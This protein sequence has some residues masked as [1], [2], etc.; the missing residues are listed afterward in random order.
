M[1]KAVA[2]VAFVGLAVGAWFLVRGTREEPAP[3][4]SSSKRT[5]A[6]KPVQ[7]ALPGKPEARTGPRYA[8]FDCARPLG[9]VARVDGVSL[10][11]ADLC[12]R[13]VP[14]GAVTSDGTERQQ[15]RHVL[16]RMIDSMLVRRALDRANLAV[17]NADV[18]AALGAMP[19]SVGADVT[20]LTAQLRERLELK[21]LVG[22][23]V[24]VTERD[25]DAELASGAPG[26]DRG[27]GM[28]VEG[29][30]ARGVD[31]KSKAR[32]ES[33]ATQLRAR[34]IDDVKHDLVP[35]APFVVGETG[36]EPELEAAAYALPKG[37]WSAALQTRVGWVV[38]RV[39]GAEAG[40]KLDEPALRARVRR[41][42]ET[43]RMQAEEQRVLEKLR[44]AA[45][46]EI[47]VDV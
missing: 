42:L 11:L 2:L 34:S 46:I 10:S 20:L 44:G 40:T 8:P 13:L 26:I 27:Q 43:R 41:A 29:F 31:A 30:I 4:A 1:R 9:E 36:V 15:A 18:D 47:L 6:A 28:R 7:P 33:L 24:E 38:I 21:K 22:K 25:V 37:K 5:V 32:A 35:L 3:A 39:V 19:P 12:T 17:T 14:L 23:K 16:E 45:R